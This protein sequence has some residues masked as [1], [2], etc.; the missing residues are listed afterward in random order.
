MK[1]HACSDEAVD[2]DVAALADPE[3]P[4][5]RLQIVA[6]IPRR[7]DD[8][9]PACDTSQLNERH[10]HNRNLASCE[11]Y[12]K[13]HCKTSRCT[14][15][16]CCCQY[17]CND[18]MR[19]EGRSKLVFRCQH[20]FPDTLK[21]HHAGCLTLWQEQKTSVDCTVQYSMVFLRACPGIPVT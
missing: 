20:H 8:H 21:L 2:C 16:S 12:Q 10:R 3:G 19:A 15:G 18:C 17:H 1:V 4:V 5:L 14:P 11:S 9:H 6:G 13:G 7:V